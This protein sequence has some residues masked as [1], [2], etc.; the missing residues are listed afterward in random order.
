MR[1]NTPGLGGY[2]LAF[3]V[4]FGVFELVTLPFSGGYGVE[5]AY[6][7][8]LLL[9]LMVQVGFFTFGLPFLLAYGVVLALHLLVRW[10]ESQVPHLLAAALG[11]LGLACL[12]AL[13][14][15]QDGD[16]L[17]LLAALPL[18]MA[19]GR[20]VVVP[21]VERRRERAHRQIGP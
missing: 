3:A 10:E 6:A 18:S 11:G 20:A 1:P 12:L 15:D 7:L 14:V 16:R 17:L 5:P 21:L 4:A 8:P 2:V 19:L 9:Y 13:M